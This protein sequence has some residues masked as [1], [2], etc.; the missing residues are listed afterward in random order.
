MLADG[1]PVADWFERM[2]DLYGGIGRAQAAA[3]AA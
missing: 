3:P 1:D 2:L